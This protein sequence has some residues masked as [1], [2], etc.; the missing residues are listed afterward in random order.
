MGDLTFGK[1]LGAVASARA[2]LDQVYTDVCT[3]TTLESRLDAYTNLTRQVEVISPPIRCRLS[4]RSAQVDGDVH[5]AGEIRQETVILMSPDRMVSPGSELVVTHD[6][7]KE[8]YKSSGMPRVYMTHQEVP[9][10]LERRW[11]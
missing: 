3:I 5:G 11:A 8:T 1:A 7:V 4:H 9:V 6:G 10:K 2:A